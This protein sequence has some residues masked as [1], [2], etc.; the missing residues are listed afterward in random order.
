[1]SIQ[2]K[3]EP[4]NNTGKINRQAYHK[5]MA[6]TDT[7]PGDI[8]LADVL[9]VETVQRLMDKHYKLTHIGM[10][11]VDLK[12]DPLVMT[13]WQEICLKFHRVHPETAK[14][15]QES[16]RFFSRNVEQGRF[17]LYKCKNNMWDIA[18]PIFIGEKQLGNLFFGQFFF[19]DEAVD[20][21]FFREQARRYGFDEERYIA[22]LKKVPR[23]SR[24]KVEE[25]MDYYIE[26]LKIITNLS[27]GRIKLAELTDRLKTREAQFRAIFETAEDSIFI[28]DRDLRYIR[29][30]P[31]MERLFGKKSEAI[32]HLT[33]TD[34]FGVGAGEHVM[35]SDRRVLNG[36]TVE[37]FPTKPVNG[38]EKS[39]HTIKVPLR[40]ENG[41]IKGLCGIAR[42][43]TARKRA[44]DE[45]RI[46]KN[47]AEA[48]NKAKTE[49]LATMS[50]EL[51]TPLNGVIGFSEILQKTGL[52]ENQQEFLDIVLQSAHN[53]L[54]LISDILDFS[55]IESNKLE[56]I[57]DKADIRELVEKTMEVVK[58]RAREK[59][60][61]LVSDVK[62]NFPGIV[63][64]DDLRFKQVLLNLLTNAIKFTETGSVKL[65]VEKRW[66]DEEKKKVKLHFSVKDTGIGIKPEDQKK[67]FETFSQVDM[68]FTRKFGGTGLGLAISKQLLNKMGSEIGLKSS[69]GKGSDFFFDLVLPYFDEVGPRETLTESA[70]SPKSES[71]PAGLSGKKVLIVED[72][73]INM[74]F[75]KTALSKLSKELILL[76][77]ENGEEAFELFQRESPDL[78]F[79]DIVMPEVDGYQAAEKIREYNKE[80][81]IIALTAKALAEDREESLQHG[82][83]DYLSKPVSVDAIR[84]MI[85]KYL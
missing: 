38:V 60:L 64:L 66:I 84:D 41:K 45:I 21:D 71:A 76:E 37:E 51:R 2:K 9:D 34:L 58:Y 14:N 75:A 62:K 10:A 6:E 20:E 8:E 29:V 74:R 80:I 82:M 32:S 79:M 4:E 57:T 59:D 72:D 3:K 16:D 31:A 27:F 52:D 49:F 43:I 46:A 63:S 67:I 35:A 56:L 13:G 61:A 85:V 23:F 70:F 26:L 33:D 18:T 47:R 28:K 36:E 55:K 40:D 30:N 39:F 77:A 48:A 24:K 11:I 44:E 50:H 1:M 42:D 73:R 12:G 22:A 54:D 68:S 65:S 17:N 15:C 5:E 78:I 19:D 83:D 25:A 81:P 7:D 69:T 53:L